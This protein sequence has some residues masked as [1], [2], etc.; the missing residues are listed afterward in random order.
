M[1]KGVGVMNAGPTIFIVDDDTQVRKSMARLLSASGL[2]VAAY[3][4]GQ[5][6]L[7]HFDAKTPGCLLLDLSMPG[8]S[9]LQ[10]QEALNSRGHVPPIVFLTGRAEV[11]DSVRAL[12]HGAME[13][14]TKPVDEPTLLDAIRNAVEKDRVDRKTR[15]ELADIHR[16]LATLTPRES[17]V[18][19]FVVS[20]LLN[21]QTA[22][23]LGT[24]EKTIKV[25]RAHIME[26]MQVSTLAK[27]V[28]LA[29]RAGIVPDA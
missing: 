20:G 24:T 7:D 21:K 28:Q 17:Q 22:G 26:K 3:E 10:V 23:K 11:S 13:F 8:F 29:I 9:G 6:Y 2:E 5:E 18:L 15:D 4:S 12:K 19:R 14:L 16:R 25:H 27:L 1:Y